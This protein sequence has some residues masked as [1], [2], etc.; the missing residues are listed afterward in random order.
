MLYNKG[1]PTEFCG[2]QFLKCI[3]RGLQH[4]YLRRDEP[5]LLTQEREQQRIIE[6]R[7]RTY[8]RSP[9][10]LQQSHATCKMYYVATAMTEN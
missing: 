8:D 3:A 6:D 10:G 5:G 4:E 1:N 2:F 7:Q 9:S